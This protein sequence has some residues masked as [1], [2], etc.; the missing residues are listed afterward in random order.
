MRLP[1]WTLKRILAA[2]Y[3]PLILIWL[4]VNLVY[5]SSI[6]FR[7]D[8]LANQV[9]GVL[10]DIT[11]LLASFAVI[12]YWWHNYLHGRDAHALKNL[13]RVAGKQITVTTTELLRIAT[14]DVDVENEEALN[15]NVKGCGRRLAWCSDI[16]RS[17]MSRV[18][19][20]V[21]AYG[22]DGKF[23]AYLIDM[24]QYLHRL[25]NVR[26]RLDLTVDIVND[27]KQLQNLIR[28]AS[29]EGGHS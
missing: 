26:H 16:L 14:Q 13:L 1:S 9:F 10:S 18:D 29:I 25:S 22:S 28:E 5:R 24:D 2:I 6:Y 7:P 17:V 20:G 23:D 3:T 27:V 12:N 8:I 19:V 15:V 11:A 4:S 21:I